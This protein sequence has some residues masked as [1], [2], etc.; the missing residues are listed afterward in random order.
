MAGQLS[1]SLLHALQVACSIHG[2]GA[3]LSVLEGLKKAH[4]LNLESTNHG[5]FVKMHYKRRCSSST[6]SSVSTRSGSPSSDPATTGSTASL[7]REEILCLRPRLPPGLPDA[8][9]NVVCRNMPR[10]DS[11]DMPGKAQVGED[12]QHFYIF[13]DEDVIET[14]TQTN[15]DW[16]ALEAKIQFFEDKLRDLAENH[17][18]HADLQRSTLNDIRVNDNLRVLEKVKSVDWRLTLMPGEIYKILAFESTIMKLEH[19]EDGKSTGCILEVKKRDLVAFE[20][21]T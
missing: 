17:E 15:D 1:A 19:I 14:S 4:V 20:S 16:G 21:A 8:K 3:T 13:D 10:T 12:A 18:F 5:L 6:A 11:F 9:V 7:S 2:E